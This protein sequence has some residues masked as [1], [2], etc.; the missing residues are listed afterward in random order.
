VDLGSRHLITRGA[1]GW[2]WLD[3]ARY[4]DSSGYSIDSPRS[5]WKYR[6]WSLTR[7]QTCHLTMNSSLTKACRRIRFP[8]PRSIRVPRTS[9]RA[10]SQGPESIPERVSRNRSRRP[11]ADPEPRFSAYRWLCAQCRNHKFDPITQRLLSNVRF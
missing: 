4:A 5:I 10:V 1:R 9:R 2:H 6:D 3:V 11:A 7:E 8:I